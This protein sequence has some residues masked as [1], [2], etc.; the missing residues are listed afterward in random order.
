[1]LDLQNMTIAELETIKTQ[2]SKL[3][4]TKTYAELK[5]LKKSHAGKTL[6]T[7][8]IAN[9]LQCNPCAVYGIITNN[10]STKEYNHTKKKIKKQYVNTENPNDTMTITQERTYYTI[11]K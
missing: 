1:M 7:N 9:I 3:L 2:A 5:K 6:S 4:K 11:V 8:E 10:M